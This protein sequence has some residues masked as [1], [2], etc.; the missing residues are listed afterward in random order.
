MPIGKPMRANE[1][2]EMSKYSSCQFIT[3]TL[4]KLKMA[5]LVIREEIPCEPFTIMIGGDYNWRTYEW[6]NQKPKVIDKI[7]VY[8]R[9]K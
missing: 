5:N 3:A 7:A 8:T 1:I 6:E 9:I 4:K 2:A